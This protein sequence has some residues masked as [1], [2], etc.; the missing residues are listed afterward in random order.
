M[1]VAL[2][3]V[4]WLIA[5]GCATVHDQFTVSNVNG[6]I[7]KQCAGSGDPTDRAACESECRRN[8]GR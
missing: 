4:A 2:V 8:Y 7:Q 3:A 1:K 5:T 6:C